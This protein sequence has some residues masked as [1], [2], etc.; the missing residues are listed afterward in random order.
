MQLN[1]ELEAVKEEKQT[2]EL[3]LKVLEIKP[4]NITKTAM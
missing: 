3:A 2:A 1:F 4:V